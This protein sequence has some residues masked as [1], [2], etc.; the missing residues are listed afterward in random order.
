[1]AI[2]TNQ[3]AEV[4]LPL[5]RERVLE[6]AI[7]LADTHGVEALTMRRLGQELGVEAMSL[8]NHVANKEEILSGIA[9]M[10]FAEITLPGG[11]DWKAELRKSAISSHDV[12]RRHPWAPGVLS[13][14]RISPARMQWMEAVLRTLREAG[15]S[16]ELAC[17]AYH[18][19]DSHITGF[20]L[21]LANMPATGE[22]L[23]ELAA[24]FL[25]TIDTDRLPY[26]AE[27]IEQHT[28]PPRE[29]DKGAF[30]FGLD[31]LLDGVE[32]LRDET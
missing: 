18:A 29:G 14:D 15:C 3:S 6:A 17:H 7:R 5:S 8:Y 20:T 28:H 31:L 13:P 22:A 16:P 24:G 30:A 27:H 9:E 32:R 25:Q 19:Y 10:V 4:R 23:R 12:F 21:W 2:R 11:N 26:V 1:M